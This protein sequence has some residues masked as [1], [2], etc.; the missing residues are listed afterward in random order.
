MDPVI[1]KLTGD[2]LFWG[3]VMGVCGVVL[4]HWVTRK[5]KKEEHQ[6]AVLQATVTALDDSVQDLRAQVKELE[7]RVDTAEKKSRVATEKYSVALT[8]AATLRIAATGLFA[9]H[10]KLPG[11]DHAELPPVPALIEADMRHNWPGAFEE[12]SVGNGQHT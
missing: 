12:T 8:H 7:G 3:A 2:P 5:S 11:F 9:R 6:L 4:G 10:A 1:V